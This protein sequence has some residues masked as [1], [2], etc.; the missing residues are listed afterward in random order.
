MSQRH[1]RDALDY[2]ATNCRRFHLQWTSPHG[3]SAFFLAG[4]AG[5]TDKR[6]AVGAFCHEKEYGINCI[7]LLVCTQ[8]MHSRASNLGVEPALPTFSVRDPLVVDLG[9]RPRQLDS[10]R[11][12]AVQLGSHVHTTSPCGRGPCRC[13]CTMAWG[14]RCRRIALLQATDPTWCAFVT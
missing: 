12:C 14:R 7:L 3:A 10:L 8:R 1:A 6:T 11:Q 9:H 2:V 13:F 5:R 4:R